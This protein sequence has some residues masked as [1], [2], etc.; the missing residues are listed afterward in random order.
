M[1]CIWSVVIDPDDQSRVK[2]PY[3]KDNRDLE[4]AL[5]RKG[6][7]GKLPPVY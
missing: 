5:G 2:I 4:V 3:A 6:N 7:G 1:T